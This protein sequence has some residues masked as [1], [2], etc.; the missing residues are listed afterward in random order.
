M[1]LISSRPAQQQQ[2]QQQRKECRFENA[3]ADASAGARAPPTSRPLWDHP[4]DMTC[5]L[6]DECAAGSQFVTH[7]TGRV[8]ARLGLRSTPI[9]TK[10]FESLLQLVDNTCKDSFDL[11]LALYKYN[12]NAASQMQALE[13]AL[14]DVAHQLRPNDKRLKR[15]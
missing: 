15:S 4:V 5:E 14:N 10:G 3:A 11:F 13:D 8:L 6:H 2:Q 1:I 7:F 12:P 9:N